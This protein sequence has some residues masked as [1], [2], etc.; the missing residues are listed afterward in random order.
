MGPELATWC[1]WRLHV[2]T[3][4]SRSVRSCICSTCLVFH[5][6]QGTHFTCELRYAP[7]Q[8]YWKSAVSCCAKNSAHMYIFLQCISQVS[9][10]F[11]ALCSI[12]MWW[13]RVKAE[14]EPCPVKV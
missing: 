12:A 6:L 10:L 8:S 11:F 14:A 9:N 2:S 4:Q 3:V 5:T 13:I 1:R 7:A